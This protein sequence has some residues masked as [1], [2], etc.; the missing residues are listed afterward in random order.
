[1]PAQ[2]KHSPFLVIPLRPLP[3]TL[4]TSASFAAVRDVNTRSRRSRLR[5]CS[6]ARI[7]YARLTRPKQHARASSEPEVP[8]VEKN[9]IDTQPRDGLF[10]TVIYSSFA[11][12]KRTILCLYSTTS[13]HRITYSAQPDRRTRSG[14][15]RFRISFN[16]TRKPQSH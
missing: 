5:L 4:L 14:G 13:I 15:G 1:M 2:T 9:T 6:A 16:I 7:S 8:Q 3:L 10:R 11:F 12:A